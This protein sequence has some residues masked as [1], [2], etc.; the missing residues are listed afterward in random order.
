MVRP[1]PIT[2]D[3]RGN[4]GGGY[5]G[6]GL[7]EQLLPYQLNEVSAEAPPKRGYWKRG[8][9]IRNLDL[10]SHYV[11]G[12]GWVKAKTPAEE[13][14]LS[15]LHDYY[16]DRPFVRVVD[17]LPATKDV[18]GSNHCDITVRLTRGRLIILSCTDNLIK[19]AG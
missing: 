3:I 6:A 13:E 1:F 12:R 11:N 10:D 8:R 19:G 4:Y 14:L 2:I 15:E 16:A 5:F 9:F 7:P 17:H 18:V